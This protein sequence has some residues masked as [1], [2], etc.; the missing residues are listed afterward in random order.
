MVPPSTV[1]A[2]RRIAHESTGMVTGIDLDAL[3]AIVDDGKLAIVGFG[4]EDLRQQFLHVPSV[5]LAADVAVGLAAEKLL[6][7]THTG[8]IFVPGRKGTRQQLSFADLEE[9]LCLLQKKD[10]DGRCLLRGSIVPKVHASIR[11]VAG[12]VSRVHI[13][14]YAHLLDEILT[15]TGV[16]TMIERHQTHHVDYAQPDDLNAIERLHRE[17]ARFVTDRGTPYV[18]PRSRAELQRL[19]PHTLLLRR[20]DIVV[21]KV[22]ATQVPAADDTLLVG[23]FV[24]AENHQDSQQGQ[25]LLSEAIGRF[26]EK[27]YA[28]AVAVTASDRA[29]RLFERNGHEVTAPTDWQAQLLADSRA[30][31]S[32]GRKGRGRVV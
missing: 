10:V 17:S 5:G 27:G 31:L 15:H 18:K 9:L 4:G 29:K 28:W 16:G 24:I 19:L 20:L 21:G 1:R 13:V 11:A 8:G 26:R 2:E 12:G 30:P 25:L 6:F 14:S 23:G 22:H 32:S 3:R 7:L